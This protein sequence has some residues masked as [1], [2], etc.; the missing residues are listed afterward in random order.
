[1]VSID[2]GEKGER[3]KEGPI[4]RMKG[5]DFSDTEREKKKESMYEGEV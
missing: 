4:N 1:M 3:G 5:Y 2:L